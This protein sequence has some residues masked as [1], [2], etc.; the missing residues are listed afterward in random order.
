[1]PFLKIIPS[2]SGVD[3]TNAVSYLEAGAYAV[4]FVTPLFEPKDISEE[5]FDR[6]EERARKFR[7]LVHSYK[8]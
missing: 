8:R 4:A 3:A 7:Q 5:K 2:H 1:M 6:I